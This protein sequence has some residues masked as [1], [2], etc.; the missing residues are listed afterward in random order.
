VTESDFA[1]AQIGEH[2]WSKAFIR[3]RNLID[4]RC[5]ARAASFYSTLVSRGYD[6]EAHIDVL[7]QAR[8]IYVCVPKCA[9][10]TV[11]MVLSAVAGGKAKSF[12]RIHKRRYSGLKSPSQVGLSTLYRIVSDARTLRFSFVRNPYERL[13]SAWADKFCERPLVPGNSFIDKYLRHRQELDSSLPHGPDRTLSFAD[14][15]TFA[16]ATANRRIDAHWQLQHDLLDMPGIKLDLVGKVETFGADFERVLDHLGLYCVRAPMRIAP[17]HQSRHQPWQ[18][19]Y[20]PVLADRVCRAY[21][22]DFD[23]LGY[24]RAI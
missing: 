15:V 7:P 14:F 10:T 12:E 11:K 9:S 19:Y 8:L 20:T 5:D 16:T 24:P 17:Q 22:R 4:G 1:L 23:C 2:L 18:Q 21:E 6:P 13:V 3:L